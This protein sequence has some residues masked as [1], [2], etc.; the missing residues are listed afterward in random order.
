MLFS[1]ADETIDVEGE[2]KGSKAWME[3]WP[4]SLER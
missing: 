3:E 2:S 4:I 1:G